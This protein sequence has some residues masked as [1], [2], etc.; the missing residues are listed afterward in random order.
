MAEGFLS[1]I[2]RGARNNTRRLLRDVCVRTYT[3]TSVQYQLRVCR[4]LL[5]RCAENSAEFGMVCVFV[6][7]VL[8]FYCKLQIRIRS[9]LKFIDLTVLIV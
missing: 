1:C 5:L 3:R 7:L 4:T 6:T 9:S 2:F 8:V